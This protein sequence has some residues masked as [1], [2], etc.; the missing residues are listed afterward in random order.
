[1]QKNY[2]NL[3]WLLIGFSLVLLLILILIKSD[4][5][6]QSTFLCEQV[7]ENGL[8]MEDCPAHKSKASWWIVSAFG[9]GF[10]I[11]GI[12]VYM[13]FLR[14]KGE[15]KT[16]FKA[17][18]LDDLGSEEKQIYEIIKSKGGSV[19]QTDLIKETG[20]SKVKITR[21]LDRLETKK[22]L[23]RKR[24]GMTNIIVLQ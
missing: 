21:I 14:T 20:H 16:E 19:F 12:G 2:K 24:R 6:K 15:E 4:Y 10:L 1:M 3:G 11:L 7:S 9:V 8:N 18:N 17:I 5:D 13:L 23:E 22:V